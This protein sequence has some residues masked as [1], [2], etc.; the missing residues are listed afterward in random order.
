MQNRTPTAKPTAHRPSVGLATAD[1]QPEALAME[2]FFWDMYAVTGSLDR[3][4]AIEQQ[5]TRTHQSALSV[6]AEMSSVFWV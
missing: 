3:I 2:P 4:A 5:A 1:Q 6:M